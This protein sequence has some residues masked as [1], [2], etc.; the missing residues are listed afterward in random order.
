MPIYKNIQTFNQENVQ[1]KQPL[2]FINWKA[3][4]LG[5]YRNLSS[6]WLREVRSDNYI[7]I[8]PVDAKKRNIKTGDMV[9][10][11]NDN[12][13]LE[14]VIYVTNG[15]APGVVGAAY[16]MGQTGY[17]VTRHTI[18]GKQ[19]KQLPTYNHT[20][21]TFNTP[22]KEESGFAGSR[23]DGFV[24]NEL[25]ETDKDFAHGVLFDEIGGSPGQLDMYVDVQKKLI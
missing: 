3:R 10:I 7:W 20:P 4:N 2:H 17:G 5:T 18:D 24:V 1:T 13:S 11:K 16:N 25:T 23:G 15:I 19:E 6:A 12:I 8:N 9:T 14:G 21:F 22:M